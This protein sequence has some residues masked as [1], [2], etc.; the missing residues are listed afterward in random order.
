MMMFF[1]GRT[2]LIFIEGMGM[3]YYGSIGKSVRM[4]VKGF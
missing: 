2:I 1:E 3:R 4:L